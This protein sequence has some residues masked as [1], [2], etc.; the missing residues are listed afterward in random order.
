MKQKGILLVAVFCLA[1]GVFSYDAVAGGRNPG[2]CLLFPYF[3]TYPGNLACMT[4]TNTGEED[5]AIRLVWIDC[6]FCSPEDQW[7]ELTAGDTFTF[8]DYAMNPESEMGFMY[9]YAVESV[10]STFEKDFDFLIGQEFI[11]NTWAL[12]YKEV[13]YGINAV[14]FMALSITADGLLRLDGTEYEAAPSE[15]FFPRFF[16]QDN[17]MFFS[18]VIL[19]SLTGG[20]FF[21]QQANVLVYNDNEQAFSSTVLF[22]CWALLNLT[23]VSGATSEINL[24]SSNHDPLEVW[25]GNPLP[26]GHKK[27]GW[28]KFMGDWAWNATTTFVI[29]NPSMYAVL[30]ES[31]GGHA[32]ADLPWQVEDAGTFD[33]A[34]LWSTNPWGDIPGFP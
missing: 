3:N 19:I 13:S 7:I 26:T 18:R 15:I 9:A 22:P 25:D 11:F 8:L 20:Q 32:A 5:V 12:Q 33:N 30:L 21:Q 28:I 34:V 10:G 23:E 14:P 6:C 29:D 17:Y 24:L 4:I 1:L 2:S 27:S 31:V 16:G